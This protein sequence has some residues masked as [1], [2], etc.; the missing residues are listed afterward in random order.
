MCTAKE[1]VLKL[2][3]GSTR[4]SEAFVTETSLSGSRL[5]IGLR[6][7]NTGRQ[8][9]FMPLC[10]GGKKRKRTAAD[11]PDAKELQKLA[12]IAE[13]ELREKNSPFWKKLRPKRANSRPKLQPWRKTT[14]IPN[15]GWIAA[16]AQTG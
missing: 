14:Y 6:F 7:E 3:D 5:K 1:I 10:S 13:S 2:P 4:I 15:Q 9:Y 12:R 16:R 11:L 8:H